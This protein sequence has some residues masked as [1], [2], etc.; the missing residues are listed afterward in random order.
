[1]ASNS[2]AM[3]F[4]LLLPVVPSIFRRSFAQCFALS[5]LTWISSGM[6]LGQFGG[7]IPA[8][9]HNHVV[10]TLS[11]SMLVVAISLSRNHE[12]RKR[13]SLL[14]AGMIFGL[15]IVSA[16]A[17]SR[18]QATKVLQILGWG[19]DNA[20]SMALFSSVSKCGSYLYLC[21]VSFWQAHLPLDFESYPQLNAAAWYVLMPK[22][23]S[24]ELNTIL[25]V[26]GFAFFITVFATVIASALLMKCD[27]RRKVS[28]VAVTLS[29][30][31]LAVLFGH[32][33]H[34]VWSGFPSFIWAIF[35]QI[36]FLVFMRFVPVNDFF[37]KLSVGTVFVTAMCLSYQLLL[38]VTIACFVLYMKSNKEPSGYSKSGATLAAFVISICGISL[39]SFV[40]VSPPDGLDLLTR[41]L[42][43]G[44]IP[45][46]P[47]PLLIFS[48]LSALI[49]IKNQ[50]FELKVLH[51]CLVVSSIEATALISY[52]YLAKGY[53]S[54]Y[55]M[56]FSYFLL[57]I[58]LIYLAH[59]V[60]HAESNFIKRM[61][62]AAFLST[63]FLALVFELSAPA[64]SA[65]NFQGGSISALKT[66]NAGIYT[67]DNPVCAESVF[68][69][70]GSMSQKESVDVLINKNDVVIDISGRWISVLRDDWND[71]DLEFEIAIMQSKS[72][73]DFMHILGDSKFKEKI[74]N[75]VYE[76][77][78]PVSSR[79]IAEIEMVH[80]TKAQSCTR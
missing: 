55:P 61:S 23:F 68:A 70:V 17:F 9:M 78:A 80:V 46:I 16:L 39:I 73:D 59:I 29:V 43:D 36:S 28:L 19:Y 11:I 67:G 45:G 34:V 65:L 50:V 41:I 79:Y 4:V 10:A 33:S 25:I 48:A 44:G 56:K 3:F 13:L 2:L 30:A 24:F 64:K 26:Y 20:S 53:I 52:S 15:A 7:L 60:L 8:S 38:P 54:Y 63:S 22:N 12:K 58:S 37:L 42:I 5:S 51:T 75:V 49:W 72:V 31:L 71:S 18:I 27:L 69:G 1:M 14:L 74:K 40:S 35:I 66:L 32:W 76:G 62:A 21:D 57:L 47:V 77:P 6:I